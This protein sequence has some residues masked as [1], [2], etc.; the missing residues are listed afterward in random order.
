[1][2][3]NNETLRAGIKEWLDDY[4]KAKASYG[5][6][7]NWDTSQVIDMSSMFNFASSFNQPIGGCVV[8]KV[9]NMESM[10]SYASFNQPIGNRDVNN[11]T[12][13]RRYAVMIG[14]NFLCYT[15]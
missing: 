4:K 11:V 15:F 9:T 10:F 5:H 3:F 13:M 7:S 8:S 12:K 6:I 14:N 1:M 2:K